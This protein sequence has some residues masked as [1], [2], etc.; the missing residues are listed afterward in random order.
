M[1]KPKP[2]FKQILLSK[3]DLDNIVLPCRQRP[4]APRSKIIA[5]FIV[6]TGIII[7]CQIPA[8][9]LDLPDKE[10]K[11]SPRKT[12]PFQQKITGQVTDANNAAIQ[13][14]TVTV[15]GK[16]AA[17]ITDKE[18]KFSITAADT[19]VLT[20]DM[21]GFKSREISVAGKNDL[22]VVMQQDAKE[23]EGVIVTGFQNVQKKKFTGSSVKLNADE[24]RQDGI[25]DAGRMLEGRVA[26]VS[27]QNVSGT[28]GSTPKIRIRGA[29]SLTGDNKPLWVVDGVVL[30]DIVDI[31]ADQLSSG[32]PTTLLGSSVAGLNAN[33]IETFDILK[34]AAATAMY[35]ARA[36][37]GVVVITTKK[38]KS[39]VSRLSYVSNFSQQLKPTY[40]DFN[41]MNSADQMAL[42]VEMQNKGLL[43]FSSI[44]NA[45][46][47]G[48]FGK[49]A[50]AINAYD[51]VE[52]FGLE[53]AAEPRAN[54]LK[55]YARVNT[56]WFDLLF[57]NN[58]L[59]EHSIS[60]SSGTDKSNS[61]LSVSYYGD[62][63]WTIADKVKRYTLNFRNNYNISDKVS[64]GFQTISSY[65]K[66]QAPGTVGRRSNPVEGTFNRD[67][68]INPFS[69]ALNTSRTVTAYDQ[70]GELEYFQRNYAPFNIIKEL[71]DNTLN[72]DVID[73]KLQ[74]NAIW[75]INEH[76]RY[77][78]VA[79]MRYVKSLQEHQIKDGSNMAGA[80]RAAGNSTIRGANRFL[81]RDPDNADTE[82]IVV[83]PYGGFYNRIENAL[84]NWDMRN[85]LYYST[86]INYDHNIDA[87]VGQQTRLTNRQNF[88]NTGYGYQ[89]NQGG[90]PFVDYRILKQTIESNFPYY[91]NNYT[92][93]R[94]AAFYASFKYSFRSKYNIS[95]DGRYDG[96][97]R[98]GSTSN[99]RWLPTGTVSASWNI[100]DEDFMQDI[101]EINLMAVRASYGLTAS[102]GDATNSEIIL[103]NQL[104]KRPYSNEKETQLAI[105]SLKNQDLTWEKNR[106]FNIGLDLNAFS[107]RIKFTTDI[108]FRKGFDLINA[109]K[110][111]GIGGQLYKVGNVADMKS[112]GIEFLLSGTPV[113][114]QHFSWTS[115]ATMGFNQTKVTRAENVPQI[116]Q[117]T[118]PEGY[119]KEGYPFRG[120]YSVSFETIE[121]L[122]GIPIF[123]NEKNKQS[124]AVDLQS[125]TTV[126]LVYEGPVDAKYTGGW[127]NAFSYKHFTLNIYF[128]Y[129]AGNKIRLNPIF[130][131]NYND[132]DAMPKDFNDR[133][134]IQTDE[135]ITIVPS[136]LDRLQSPQLTS[137]G[138]YPM[139]YYNY[140]TARVAKGDFIRLKSISLQ[141]NL[142]DDILKRTGLKGTS[143]MGS[144]YN[145]F[146]LHS[147]KKLKGQDPEFFNTGGVAQPIQKQFTLTIRTNI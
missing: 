108:Y 8:F 111:S 33:D 130:D 131:Q 139:N 16:S 105:E 39:G 143:V 85:T 40:G 74:G 29:T 88:S 76:F 77:E 95:L 26:G 141:Y 106:Q 2:T 21:I 60:L 31:S 117:L 142:P 63:G 101:P 126:Y 19:D 122:G 138:S 36:M 125:D 34:D 147:D 43:N 41:I 4:S 104:S 1:L 23:L 3:I 114:N 28:F 99:A 120:L 47:W 53:N 15:K 9:S 98:M 144:A 25:A 27:V 66:Q 102:M 46:T 136:I 68:D 146:L 64:V 54:F 90:I 14:V 103:L 67:F 72:I 52:G 51:P 32:D 94:F 65:R 78:M 89:Y 83:L 44:S 92:Y 42:Y 79:A 37:N 17:T 49:M 100:G 59:Q 62:N 30:E 91:G 81:Y 20:F 87:F 127:N 86:Q 93:D 12:A 61:Y 7:T 82:P 140:S 116:F 70:D 57:Q 6:F 55:R 11:H 134:T 118:Q 50:Q 112:N 109:I 133:W 137:E 110:T 128:T 84:S 22:T 119:F 18:G 24:M 48:V 113:K 75:K 124:N 107:N 96:S 123:I 35:G 13:G 10:F 58:L 97:N 132:W 45:N 145:L 135:G 5:R 56:D 73:L 71:R 80:Y 69:Y 38:G 115:T 129:A 121:G